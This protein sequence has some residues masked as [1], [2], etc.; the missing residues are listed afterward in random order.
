MENTVSGCD[1]L[2]IWLVA[3][4][5]RR[6]RTGDY[7]VFPS[8]LNGRG[9]RVRSESEWIRLKKTMAVWLL[10]YLIGLNI[11]GAVTLARSGP[12]MVDTLATGAFTLIWVVAHIS[13]RVR[14]TRQLERTPERHSSVD[15]KRVRREVMDARLAAMSIVLVV[16]FVCMIAGGIPWL[17]LDRSWTAGVLIFALGAACVGVCV[18]LLRRRETPA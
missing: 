2:I 14:L 9:Y 4:W 6:G 18:P 13:W 8:G 16:G 5:F 3:F 1:R 15:A 17:V 11:L 7:L 10:G 12:G